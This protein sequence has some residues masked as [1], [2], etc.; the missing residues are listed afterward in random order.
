MI[1]IGEPQVMWLWIDKT[2]GICFPE[3]MYATEAY[4]TQQAQRILGKRRLGY[5][6]TMAARVTIEPL[7][8]EEASAQ[9][10]E[11]AEWKAK[12]AQQEDSK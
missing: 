5:G 9:R 3:T 7:S 10:V 11:F 6:E 12:R 8:H 1:R 2:T 4:A